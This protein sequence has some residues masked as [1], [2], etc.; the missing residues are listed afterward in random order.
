MPGKQLSPVAPA[1]ATVMPARGR[2][3]EDDVPNGLAPQM[4]GEDLQPDVA[5]D[6]TESPSTEG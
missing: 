4:D 5:G 6:E 3:R 2:T 1:K